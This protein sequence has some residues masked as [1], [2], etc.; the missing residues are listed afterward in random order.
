MA[1]EVEPACRE[2]AQGGALAH[3]G[4]SEGEPGQL[5]EDP[6]PLPADVV[7]RV[8]AEVRAGRGH[9]EVPFTGQSAELVHDVPPAAELVDR[10]VAETAQALR[11]ATSRGPVA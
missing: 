9:E 7:A 5:A 1:V 3:N 2:G 6:G 10:L 11:T 8:V 4:G